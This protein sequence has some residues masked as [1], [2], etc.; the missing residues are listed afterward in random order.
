[1]VAVRGDLPAPPPPIN[2]EALPYWEAAA[3]GRLVLPVCDACGH[4]VWYP[5]SWCP[6][7]GSESVTWTELS[8]DATVY[9]CTVVRRGVGPWAAA[10]P[11]VGAYV[12]L[13]E[14]PRVLTNI[15][16]DDPDSVRVGDAVRATFVPVADPPEG[17]AAT[18]L[19][20]FTPVP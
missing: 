16:T 14:G 1:M 10:V 8:G 2:E 18:H 19:V 20:R 4:H 11:F 3:D 15:V 13:A 6:V 12:E 17:S 5:R 9:A 7:C